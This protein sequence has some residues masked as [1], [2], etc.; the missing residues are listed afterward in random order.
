[1]S[2]RVK[3]R[4]ES[5]QTSFCFLC[6]TFP[7]F[8]PP[9]PLEL[10]LERRPWKTEAVR[11]RIL[12]SSKSHPELTFSFSLIFFR[13]DFSFPSLSPLF[14]SQPETQLKKQKRNATLLVA[15]KK[16]AFDNRQYKKNLRAKAFK[17]AEAYVK[18]YKALENQEVANKRKAKAENKL[19]Y[20]PEAQ[21]VCVV[22]IRGIIG[23]SPKVRKILRLFRL[24]QIHNCVFVKMNKAT[25]NM[26]RLV[27]PF[28]AYGPPNLKTIRE[29]VYKRGFGKVDKQRIALTDNSIVDQ[30]LGKF[31]ISCMEDLIHEI[32]TCGGRFKEANNFLHPFK[33]SSPLGGFKSKLI[34]FNEGG[35]A[36]NREE[37]INGLVQRML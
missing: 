2:V 14:F 25:I 16:K 13:Y 33:L 4:K 35:D 28:I 20:E 34:H 21:V 3:E 5:L 11:L 31:N 32:F 8:Q 19:Y 36:G 12:L 27:E 26:L 18:E 6:F 10:A 1:M 37:K 15:A 9:L 24:R 17:S 29:L 22:R 7:A 30:A 23:V